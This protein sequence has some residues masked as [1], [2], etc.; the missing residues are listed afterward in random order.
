MSFAVLIRAA[1]YFTK[2]SEKAG[3]ALG[4]SQFVIGITIV[5]IGTSLPELATSFAAVFEGST[6]I[7]IGNAIGSNI[8]N[9]LLVTGFAAV[10][11]GALVV[12]RS[13]IDL[14]APLLA[15]ITILFILIILD[16]VVVFQEA[17]LLLLSYIVYI[18]YSYYSRKEKTEEKEKKKSEPFK[19]WWVL[20]VIVS[21]GFIYLGARYT[22][23]SVIEISR[24]VGISSSI[25]A[26]SAIAIGTSL[27]EGVVSIIAARKGNYEMALGNIFGSNIFNLAVVIGLPG[28]FAN[29]DVSDSIYF[30]GIPFL[31]GATLLFVISGISRKVHIWEGA[32]YLLIYGLFLGKLFGFI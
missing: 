12:K 19:W 24:V 22:V 31:I 9:I 13:L 15:G 6:E 23:E 25:I 1:S 26:L 27:P 3:L 17:L 30:I 14:D 5:S 11:V 8:A 21:A 29:L 2:Y 20:I 16:R 10:I 18:L 28:L 4:V 32:I 7:V